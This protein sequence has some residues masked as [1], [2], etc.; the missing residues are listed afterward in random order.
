MLDMIKSRNWP[1][2]L[3]FFLFI[4]MMSAGYYYNLTFVQLGLDDFSSQR[5]G[6]SA[7]AVAR[8]MALL[9]LLTSA[10][11]IGF[12][13]WM[14]KRGWGRRFRLKLRLSFGVVLAQTV[15]TWLCSFVG[16][17]TGFIA[18]L[19]GVSLALGV[20]VPVMFSMMVDLVP[21]RLRG[22]AA[23]S[24]TAIAY[25]ASNA[26]SS[27]WTFEAFRQQSLLIL[28]PGTL[29]MGI[30]TFMRHPWLDKI[31]RNHK[32]PGFAQGR[33]V[34][35][36]GAHLNG[37]SRLLRLIFIMFAIYFVD[38]LG[39]LRLLKTPLYMNS[40][41]QSPDINIHLF[42]AGVHVVA[43][44][45]AGV[46]YASLRQRPLFLWIFGI[47]ALT[48]L[49]YSIH[50]RTEAASG[51]LSMPMLYAVAVSLY[52][53][54]SFAIWAD[55]SNPDTICLNS[56]LGVALSGWSATFLSTGLAIS[57]GES[58]SLERH[59]QVVDSLAMVFF[60]AMLLLTLFHPAKNQAK[61]AP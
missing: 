40:A 13:A 52:T 20:G 25:F 56:A 15:L 45:A 6:L 22:A 12:G 3:G 9:A 41:W 1:A 33:F 39:F 44:L 8:D 4:G 61:T 49:Q 19:A 50:I 28:I 30:M 48:H 16:N 21:V 55:I 17:E 11:A 37:T 2:L 18:W 24:I 26:F 47:F 58:L 32:L 46:L 36:K 10:V 5:L 43:A 14:Q 23:A 31:S 7:G 42:I 38:S 27:Q 29:G 34:N 57:L 35:R 54:V 53:V 51:T 59:I 60:A